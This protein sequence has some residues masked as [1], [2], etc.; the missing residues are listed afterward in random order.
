VV[1]P[2]SL[3]NFGWPCYESQPRHLGYDGAIL[4]VCENLHGQAGAV[5]ST[6]FAHH[7]TAQYLR[8]LADDKPW[9]AFCL[10]CGRGGRPYPRRL[11]EGV[12]ADSARYSSHRPA[13]GGST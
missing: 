5:T 3:K 2:G 4:N 1:D 11:D 7:H 13:S 6:H 12:P 10:P 8:L 9:E